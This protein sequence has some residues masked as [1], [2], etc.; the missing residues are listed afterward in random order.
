[1]FMALGQL[2][3]MLD[4]YSEPG[5]APKLSLAVDLGPH[6]IHGHLGPP[7]SIQQ[8]APRS[9]T[10]TFAQ[11]F[12]GLWSGT[13]WLGRYEKKHSPTHTHPDHRTSFINFLHLL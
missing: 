1:M 3:C 4:A 9:V 11:P 12:N 13:A 7:M 8:V 6:L 2:D 5:D 10:H